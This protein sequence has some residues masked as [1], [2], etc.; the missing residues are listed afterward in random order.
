[1]T[2]WRSLNIQHRNNYSETDI[3]DSY[4]DTLQK[5]LSIL[6]TQIS[7]SHFENKN[8]YDNKCALLLSNKLVNRVKTSD[9]E[10]KNAY[11]PIA[12]ISLTTRYPEP[13]IFS[14]SNPTEFVINS[15]RDLKFF[16]TDF[17]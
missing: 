13:T 1:M 16:L 7:V 11:A 4:G 8:I 17:K 5:P 14:L 15:G 6:V 9:G 2:Y 12:Y 10:I 3:V